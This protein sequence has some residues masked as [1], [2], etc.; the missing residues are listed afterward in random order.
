MKHIL[1]L[2]SLSIF[3]GCSSEQ[4]NNKTEQE[5]NLQPELKAAEKAESKESEVVDIETLTQGMVKFEGGW[6]SIG[7]NDRMPNE[8]PTFQKEVKAF[9]L[10]QYLVSVAQFR[11]FIASTAYKTDA[12]K[13][14]DSGVFDFDAGSWSLLKGANWEFPLGRDQPKAEDNHPVTHV[15]W[16][17]AT[18][19]AKWIGKRLPSEF[20]WEWAAKNGQESNDKYA[21][22][23]ELI[24]NGQYKANVWQGD[25]K[26]VVLDGYL[27][28]SPV[29]AFGLLESGLADM[30]GNVWQWCANVYASY[31]GSPQPI[32][33]KSN[34]KSTRGGSFMMDPAGDLS[35]TTTFR[36][37]NTDDTSLFNTGF[38]CAL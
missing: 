23:D 1:L 27:M 24:V 30:G 20:E 3:F 8:A 21:W 2:L 32:P 9:Y 5:K 34:T 10:D 25:T 33:A 31:P 37:G 7:S 26:P 4:K 35:F 18:T 14:G 29:G 16:N 15:S 22:G 19:Y 11:V 28:T 38:R 12:D 17:D 6:M 13:F 36:A